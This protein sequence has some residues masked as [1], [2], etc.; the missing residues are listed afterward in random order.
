MTPAILG[1]K[2]IKDTQSANKTKERILASYWWPVTD[3][4][5]KN[6]ITIIDK[7]HKT[8]KDKRPLPQCSEPNQRVHMDLFCPLKTTS[9]GKRYILCV[10]DAFSMYAEL[11]AI[12][13]KSVVSVASAILSRWL[14]RHG[15]PLEF[16]SDNGTEFCNQII[17]QLLKLLDINKDNQFSLP[18]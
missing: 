8:R 10:T 3:S 17:E 12:P 18:S 5:I 6:H 16:V 15:L 2:I 4:Q 1:D 11:V 13:D 7:C 9:S 14:C